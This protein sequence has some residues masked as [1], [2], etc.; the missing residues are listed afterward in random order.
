MLLQIILKYQ[1]WSFSPTKVKINLGEMI[2][3]HNRRHIFFFCHLPLS[4]WP[5]ETSSFFC[6]G[7][8]RGRW[9]Y[10]SCVVPKYKNSCPLPA[11]HVWYKNV[12]LEEFWCQRIGV[13]LFCK[14]FSTGKDSQKDL[15]AAAISYLLILGWWWYPAR[16]IDSRAF[17]NVGSGV[18]IW[19]LCHLSWVLEDF[20]QCFFFKIIA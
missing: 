16:G 6:W 12:K 2:M 15:Y 7:S 14:R 20:E 5:P 11:P 9:E 1:L 17:N 8:K 3:M 4:S 18:K 13:L 19:G 10:N